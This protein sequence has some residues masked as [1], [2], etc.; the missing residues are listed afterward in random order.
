[1][2]LMAVYGKQR[3]HGEAVFLKVVPP[4]EKWE[5]RVVP[6]FRRERWDPAKIEML[7]LG[8]N[9]TVPDITYSVRNVRVIRTAK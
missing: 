1:M 3:E 9:S 6:G 7:R 5:E 2:L 8:L 4:S